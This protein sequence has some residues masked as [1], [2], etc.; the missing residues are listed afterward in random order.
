M[1]R[2]SLLALLVTCTG[3]FADEALPL[4]EAP[5]ADAKSEHKALQPDNSLILETKGDG[6]KR[7]LVAAEVCMREGGP[8]EMFVC[9]K[10]SKE[11]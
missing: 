2:T 11:A 5:K 8:L 1:I 4:P 3:A 9:K 6:A 7:V 10:S